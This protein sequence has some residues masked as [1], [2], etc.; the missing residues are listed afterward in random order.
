V[1][2]DR[3]GRWPRRA[4]PPRGGAIGPGRVSGTPAE[5]L[6]SSASQTGGKGVIP[7]RAPEARHARKLGRRGVD[8]V[9]ARAVC[10]R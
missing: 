8:T 3:R 6:E 4:R 5:R 7:G 9:L 2:A 1:G 10:T